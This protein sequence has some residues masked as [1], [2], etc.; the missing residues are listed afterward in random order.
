MYRMSRQAS[1]SREPTVRFVR[2]FHAWTDGKLWLYEHGAVV[3]P[4]KIMAVVRYARE[5]IGVEHVV[6]DSLMKCGM[7]TDDYNAQ[8]A[9]V[10]RLCVYAR[11]SGCHVHIVA[12][13][14]KGDGEHA[15]MDKHDI[16]GASEITDLVDNVFTLW[17]NKPKEERVRMG[18]ADDEDMAK[19][20]ALL[21]CV[22]NRHGEWEGSVALW[23]HADSFQYLGTS[24]DR[25]ID[26]IGLSESM[27]ER[28]AMGVA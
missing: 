26:F 19:P 16:K 9:L 21:S 18:A 11:D 8:K 2:D 15:K 22:K 23:Y 3:K 14:R 25:P 4:D 17:R 7:A 27:L 24:G 13:G 1:G 5:A 10:D 20:D 12:H 28:R 6:I